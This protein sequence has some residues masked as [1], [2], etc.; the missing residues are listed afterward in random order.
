MASSHE[1]EPMAVCTLL[2]DLGK[3]LDKLDI[4][5]TLLQLKAFTIDLKRGKLVYVPKVPIFR[6]LLPA[7]W[8]G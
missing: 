6:G 4:V 7:S 5:A 1:G 2:V 8:A 3:C